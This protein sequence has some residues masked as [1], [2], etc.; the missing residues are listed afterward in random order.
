MQEEFDSP[1]ENK[2]WGLSATPSNRTTL[3]G[4]WVFKMKRG[5]EREI[6]CFKAQYV[7]KA[8]Q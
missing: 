4:K 7:V 3:G 6:T 2:T 5:P 1:I 8:F